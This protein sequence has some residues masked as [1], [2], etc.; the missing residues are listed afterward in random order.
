MIFK[1]THL[2]IEVYTIVYGQQKVI[3]EPDYDHDETRGYLNYVTRHMVV[4]VY[5]C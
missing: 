3:S 1:D 4:L 2:C 5:T